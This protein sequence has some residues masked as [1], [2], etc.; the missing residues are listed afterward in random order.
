MADLLTQSAAAARPA[1]LLRRIQDRVTG[2]DEPDPHTLNLALAS[3]A[4]QAA[5]G[6]VLALGQYAPSTS[7][8][9]EAL[10]RSPS[11]IADPWAPGVLRTV[12]DDGDVLLVG[13]GLTMVDVSLVLDRPGRVLHAV[14]RGGL[15]PQ[16]HGAHPPARSLPPP[17]GLDD[18]ADLTQLRRAIL[19]HILAEQRTHGDWRPAFDSLRPVTESLWQRLT[20]ADKARF[21]AR[22]SRLWETHRHR[23]APVTGA[24]LRN[25]RM[26]GRLRVAAGSVTA[27]EPGPDG[28][29]LTVRLSDGRELRVAA[30]VNCTGPEVDFQRC[31][32]PLPQA[33][34]RSGQARSGPLGLGL[35]TA[36][37]GRVLN[38]AGQARLP[39]WTLGAARRGSLWETTAVPELRV[40]AL[41]L[42][43]SVLDALVLPAESR[44]AESPASH[45]SS[46]S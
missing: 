5:D 16:V 7:W 40:Q 41:D 46:G 37:D 45:R 19:R 8:A 15:V 4:A 29:A 23:V 38:A 6:V 18:C 36:A 11:F 21:L 43:A 25:M 9:P 32:D 44:R 34:F 10:R 12:P 31:S 14:S 24:V 2:L 17:P 42:A 30:V 20:P 28:R 3:G 1:G 39:L 13:T 35:D 27:V 33:L 22:D 26:A